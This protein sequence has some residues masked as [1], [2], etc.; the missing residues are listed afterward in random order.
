MDRHKIFRRLA[1]IANFAK[2]AFQ[3]TSSFASLAM[4][5]ELVSLLMGDSSRMTK[6]LKFSFKDHLNGPPV[7][8]QSAIFS[9]CLSAAGCQ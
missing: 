1:V 5:A 7:R 2:E 6:A 9:S 8:A 3:I 4:V